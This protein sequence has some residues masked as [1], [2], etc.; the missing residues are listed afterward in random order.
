M[1][2]KHKKH[3]K[4]DKNP[5][6]IEVTRDLIAEPPLKLVLK[7]G[8]KTQ[9]A[10]TGI[11]DFRVS[12]P[13]LEPTVAP[14]S[15]EENRDTPKESHQKK[16]KK[17]RK[18]HDVEHSTSEQERAADSSQDQAE[19]MDVDSEPVE[20]KPKEPISSKKKS[21][22]K[23]RYHEEDSERAE[24]LDQRSTAS[25]KIHREPKIEP[26]QH[27]PTPSISRE[28]EKIMNKIALKKVLESLQKIIQR[29]DVDQF[30]AWPVN[31]VIAPGYSSIIQQPMDFSNMKK[32]IDCNEYSSLD[33]YK[34][35]FSLMCENATIY[36][37]PE[38]IY[39]KAAKRLHAVGLKCMSKEKLMLLKRSFGYRE[40]SDP[41][42]SRIKL[43]KKLMQSDA[44]LSTEDSSVMEAIDSEDSNMAPTIGSGS[45]GDVTEEESAEE[46]IEQA[47]EAAKDARARLTARFPK[48]KLGFLRRDK[49]GTTT[50]AILNRSQ[51]G[52][53]E[54]KPVNLGML[55]GKLTQG[56]GTLPGFREDK[57]NK[58][59]PVAY[60]ANGPFNSH[61]PQYD[62][63]FANI[64]KEESDLLYST[65]GDE[66]GAQYAQ[67]I[68]EYVEN[69]DD[70]VVSLVDGMLDTLTKG[71]HSKTMALLK[72][73]S[74]DKEAAK[75]DTSTVSA[76]TQKETSSN[77]EAVKEEQETPETNIQFDSLKSLSDIGI[78]MSFLPSLE[79]LLGSEAD[80]V[81]AI[82][83]AEIDNKLKSTSD[84]INELEKTQTARLSRKP[85]NHLQFVAK[86]SEQESSIAEKLT[87]QLLSLTSKIKPSD[88]VPV[89]AVRDAL[90]IAT[91]VD[92]EVTEECLIVGESSLD[93]P[94]DIQMTQVTS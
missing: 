38:T 8:S 66:A 16:K 75:T 19:S 62:S 51:P 55:T 69:C 45:I 76:G 5:V 79:K 2:K 52:V 89:G 59:I 60:I 49:S 27:P 36:N 26:M 92:K 91:D 93:V 28:K 83:S 39:Y 84:L 94:T 67:S 72:Q 42:K 71:Q 18:W 47:L 41:G 24:S 86:P 10:K 30:F 50:L 90:G 29:K 65:Y 40:S 54:N 53:D 61:G 13:K 7:V 74:V 1:G 46:I 32:K 68:K 81:P 25:E 88:V 35:D 9:D 56:T 63:S 85:P 44:D 31:D 14:V 78:D 57:R 58:A 33:E 80:S 3:H 15:T 43:S 6:D 12:K 22:K 70:Y 82:D 20:E 87:Q 17:K 23:Q 48:S 37:R 77:Q 21:S 64:S 11:K 73:K 34:A 4:S